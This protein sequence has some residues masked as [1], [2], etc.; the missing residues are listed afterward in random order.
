MRIAASATAGLC[1]TIVQALEPERQ[2]ADSAT[3]RPA[4]KNPHRIPVKAR[5]ILFSSALLPPPER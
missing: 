5:N 3:W 2:R 1:R 4:G